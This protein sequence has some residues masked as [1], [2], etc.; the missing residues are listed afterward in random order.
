[1]KFP[2]LLDSE[3]KKHHGES[4]QKR[5][6]KPQQLNP[7]KAVLFFSYVWDLFCGWEFF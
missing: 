7:I 2:H 3:V 5:P 1:M 4:D 6:D